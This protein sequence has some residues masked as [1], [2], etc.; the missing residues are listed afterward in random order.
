M[1]DIRLA[2]QYSIYNRK[3]VEA[4]EKA[5]CYYCLSIFSPEEISDYC[6]DGT[7]VLCPK[8]GIDSVLGSQSGYTI[9]LATL[10]KL[11][12]YWF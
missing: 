10:K 8:C 9:D 5:G 2:S 4:S 7:T 6:D 3:Q 1:M 11:K 12:Q